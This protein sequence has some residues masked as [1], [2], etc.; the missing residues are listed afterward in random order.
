MP[1]SPTIDSLGLKHCSHTTSVRCPTCMTYDHPNLI[2]DLILANSFC[3]GSNLNHSSTRILVAARCG[4]YSYIEAIWHSALLL[5]C[6]EHHNGQ[7]RAT[8]TSPIAYHETLLSSLSFHLHSRFRFARIPQVSTNQ[9]A[10]TLPI[11]H[12]S[13]PNSQ[14]R[15]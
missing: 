13:R 3:S 5:P 1:R 9:H 11:S 14:G 6:C 10:Y 12:I 7:I 2:S 8:A 4:G 15:S